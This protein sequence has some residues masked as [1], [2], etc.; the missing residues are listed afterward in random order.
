[1]EYLDDL[2]LPEKEFVPDGL[3]VWDWMKGRL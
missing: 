3:Q 2:L 1:M